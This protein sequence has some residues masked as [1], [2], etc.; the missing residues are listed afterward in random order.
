MHTDSLPKEKGCL[1]NLMEITEQKNIEK[2]LEAPDKYTL[3]CKQYLPFYKTCIASFLPH[4]ICKHIDI[5]SALLN[6]KV[7]QEK[8]ITK[9]LHSGRSY[10]T[11][12]PQLSISNNGYYLAHNV[13]NHVILVKNICFNLIN[14]KTKEFLT[15]FRAADRN[16]IC[17]SP[18]NKYCIMGGGNAC[19]TGIYNLSNKRMWNIVDYTNDQVFEVIISNDSRYI[20]IKCGPTYAKALYELR[21]ID[22]QEKVVE[23]YL[24][25]PMHGSM[26]AAFHPD[27]KHIVHNRSDDKKRNTLYSYEII[28]TG[29]HISR[30]D[31]QITEYNESVNCINTLEFN[32]D[33]TRIIAETQLTDSDACGHI[34]F[35]IENLD[36][37]TSV[38]LPPQ[39][40][41]QT[42]KLPV[43]S[44]PHTK[45][46]THITDNGCTLQLFNEAAHV[47]ATHNAPHNSYISALAT[48][49]TGNYL[50]IGHSNGTIIIWDLCSKNKTIITSNG[51]I[52]SLTFG[53]NQLLL[54][55]SKLGDVWNTPNPTPT[56]GRALLL[57]VYG[58][59]IFN[60]GNNI[61]NS[62]MSKNGKNIIIISLELKWD[63]QALIPNWNRLLTL[64][65]YDLHDKQIAE[66]YKTQKNTSTLAKMCM[67]NLQQPTCIKSTLANN[68]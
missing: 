10:N 30:W 46:I 55:Q 21:E 5:F 66:I 6:N 22:A 24:E 38:I 19:N 9:I 14:L 60:F 58:N 68:S 20:L 34:V 54:S 56:P 65:S 43:L 47:I 18:N 32:N 41:H 7:I 62:I 44:I 61:V 11:D 36:N 53:N 2:K 8:C 25:W 49:N 59:T 16:S 52:E 4:D 29:M 33:N 64:T 37:V 31:K 51:V 42:K 28:S 13:C 50:A 57:D 39:S 27:G 35:N 48:D 63:D 45:M 3:F 1:Y 26:A 15:T 67:L 12:A 23:H 17:F 40:C